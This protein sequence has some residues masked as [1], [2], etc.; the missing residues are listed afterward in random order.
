M[1]HYQPPTPMQ[2]DNSINKGFASQTIKQKRSKA[3][4]MRFYW[5][6]DCVR[7]KQFLIYWHPGSTNLGDCHTKQHLP[8]HHH[9][10]RTNY[11]HTTNQ[12]ANHVIS[13]LLQGCVKS[14][15]Q[16]STINVTR[17]SGLISQKLT[18]TQLVTNP[19]HKRQLATVCSPLNE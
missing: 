17:K 8:A 6:Q 15:P 12:L 7:Q 13:L 3:I 16:S 14:S 4:D 18:I 11:L 10:M 9:L 1:G 5:V 2:V 19:G